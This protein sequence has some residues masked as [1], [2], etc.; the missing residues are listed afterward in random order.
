MVRAHIELSVYPK[1]VRAGGSV[2]VAGRLIDEA[3]RP[4]PAADV[5]ILRDEAVL[6]TVKTDSRGRFVHVDIVPAGTHDYR[7]SFAGGYVP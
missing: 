4:I 3:E 5:D 2:R 6:V 1:K 7:A